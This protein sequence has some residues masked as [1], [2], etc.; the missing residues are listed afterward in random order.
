MYPVTT[1]RRLQ[2]RRRN[3][4]DRR[5]ERRQL[6]LGPQG[7]SLIGNQFGTEEDTNRNQINVKID[8]QF[9]NRHKL[10]GGFTWER[11]NNVSNPSAWPGG[12]NGADREPSVF[13][14]AG[15][16]L[17]SSLV[18]EARLGLRYNI[19]GNTQPC[20]L[21]GVRDKVYAYEPSVNGFRCWRVRRRSAITFSK[22]RNTV[23]SVSPMWTYGDTLS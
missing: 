5:F 9:N 23:T 20:D 3:F 17:S 8:H 10:S 22:V 21:D 15:L 18:N 14:P 4:I 12:F 13:T 7:D 19:S 16:P 11:Q 2:R 6:P 1:G